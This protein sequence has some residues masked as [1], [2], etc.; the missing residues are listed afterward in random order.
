MWP[1]IT[2]QAADRQWLV[3]DIGE[4]EP[5]GLRLEATQ[6]GEGSACPETLRKIRKT[7]D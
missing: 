3:G 2:K 1:A 7:L 6:E 4:P 5:P